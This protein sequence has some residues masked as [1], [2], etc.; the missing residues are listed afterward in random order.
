MVSKY[1]L[2]S[3]QVYRGHGRKIKAGVRSTQQEEKH[4]IIDGEQAF[5]TSTFNLK[6]EFDKNSTQIRRAASQ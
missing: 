6:D 3:S 1:F 5:Y 2:D 4:N